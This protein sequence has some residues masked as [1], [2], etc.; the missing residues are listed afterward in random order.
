MIYFVIA[1]HPTMFDTTIHRDTVFIE[2]LNSR[3]GVANYAELFQ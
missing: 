2:Y 3:T 1:I